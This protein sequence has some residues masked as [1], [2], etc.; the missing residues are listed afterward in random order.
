MTLSIAKLPLEKLTRGRYQ[1][2]RHFDTEALEELADS[3]K[4]NG[5]IQPI[6]VRPTGHAY[7]IIAGERRWRASQLAGLTEINCIIKEYSDEQAAVITTLENWQREDLNPIE[8]AKGLQQ[9]IDEFGYLH[10]EVAAIIST[11]RSKVTNLLRL[12]QLVESVQVLLIEG[13]LSEGHGK[14]LAA[15]PPALQISIAEQAVLQ[16]WSVR[17]TEQMVKQIVKTSHL[18][19]SKP[20]PDI[21]RLERV[22]ADQLATE[23]AVDVTTDTGGWLKIKFY[24]ND[25]LAGILKRIGIDQ[26][27]D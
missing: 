5:L 14:M 20:N 17:K 2:R 4:K 6:V 9:M 10:E 27:C 1:S 18:P 16:M 21:K 12:L 22:I 26:E 8:I 25:T 23:V 13:K 24:N 19:P 7:E 3:I 15:L 11:S